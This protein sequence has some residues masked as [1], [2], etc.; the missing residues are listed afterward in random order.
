V[1]FR[2]KDQP[3]VEKVI[4]MLR[5]SFLL[6]LS[7]K[8]LAEVN[9]TEGKLKLRSELLNRANQV[10]PKSKILGIYFTEFVVQ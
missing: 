5:D 9:S 10:M 4:P 3:E 2:S 7:S 1:L 8:T 6:L